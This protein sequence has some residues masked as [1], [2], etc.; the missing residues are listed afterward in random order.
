MLLNTK[1]FLQAAGKITPLLTSRLPNE[2]RSFFFIPNIEDETVTICGTDGAVTITEKIGYTPTNAS[3]NTVVVINAEKLVAIA[4]GAPETFEM[5]YDSDSELVD[6]KV[7]QA[8]I[9]LRKLLDNS[10]ELFDLAI[11]ENVEFEDVFNTSE[12]ITTLKVIQKAV[13]SSSVELSSRTIFLQDNKAIVGNDSFIS[14]V[15]LTSKDVY[16]LSDTVIKLILKNTVGTTKESTLAFK[17]FG[18]NR[19]LIKTE[20]G[21]LLFQE[22]DVFA[23]DMSALENM[24]VDTT[25]TVDKTEL[26]NAITLTSLTANTHGIKLSWNEK[27]NIVLDTVSEHETANVELLNIGDTKGLKHGE[28]HSCIIPVHEF[29]KFVKMLVDEKATLEFDTEY[30]M[31]QIK[32]ENNGVLTAIAVVPQSEVTE[33]K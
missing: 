29:S 10:K 19:I 25:A 30:S 9:S 5:H 18:D 17:N 23:P 16:S 32:D 24:I 28:L 11:A 15:E 2:L 20:N 14:H 13:D 31:V 3:D 8:N 12:F 7:G 33:W 27:G 26:I 6:I 4:K 1:T 22:E 21:T